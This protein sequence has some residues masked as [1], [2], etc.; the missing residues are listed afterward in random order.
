MQEFVLIKEIRKGEHIYEVLLETLCGLH[1]LQPG[2]RPRSPS[3]PSLALAVLTPPRNVWVGRSPLA[4]IFSAA[5]K[6]PSR[7]FAFKMILFIFF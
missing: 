1:S 5:L 3:V 7:V 6:S 2:Q 4:F